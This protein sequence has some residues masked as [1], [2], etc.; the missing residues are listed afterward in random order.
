M[1]IRA[2]CHTGAGVFTGAPPGSV[3]NARPFEV[4]AR[5]G[6]T[7]MFIVFVCFTLTR[8]APLGAAPKARSPI[9]VGKP[10][11][12]G[13]PP[14]TAVPVAGAA[15]LTAGAAFGADVS[16]TPRRLAQEAGEPDWRMG[17]GYFAQ[18]AETV[19]ESRFNSCYKSLEQQMQNIPRARRILMRG[20][21]LA[22][23]WRQ[24]SAA[25]RF[26]RQVSKRSGTSRNKGLL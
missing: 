11:P 25:L 21:Y 4:V 3:P 24:D 2:G 18:R 17:E 1:K 20:E 15:Q 22:Q 6:P 10:P 19:N 8:R 7:R 12:R 26:P 23:P 14:F 16:E 13:I 5:A 9:C